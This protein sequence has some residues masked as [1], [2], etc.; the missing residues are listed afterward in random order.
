ML[1]KIN[2]ITRNYVIFDLL[3]YQ[4]NKILDKL[5]EICFVKQL[6]ENSIKKCTE[7]VQ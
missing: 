5:H 7:K 6:P 4:T 1:N 2:Y 3:F